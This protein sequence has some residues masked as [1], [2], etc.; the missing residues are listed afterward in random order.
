[1]R[2]WLIGVSLLVTSGVSAQ[3]AQD[4]FFDSNGVRIRYLDQGSGEPV[5]LIHG[6]TRSIDTNWIDTGVFENLARDH[7]VIA[8]D[9]R[10]HAVR[11][12]NISATIA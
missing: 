5:L 10:G 3:S 6:Y 9:L 12:A 7:R 2:W 11:P 4:K 1:M 8:F